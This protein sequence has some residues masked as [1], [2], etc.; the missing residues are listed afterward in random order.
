M[1]KAR[2]QVVYFISAILLLTTRLNAVTQV[3]GTVILFSQISV[4]R[5][6]GAA[7]DCPSPGHLQLDTCLEMSKKAPREGK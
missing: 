7:D 2:T 3:T 4:R 6:E 1:L 5:H